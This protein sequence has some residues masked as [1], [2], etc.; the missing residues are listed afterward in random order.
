MKSSGFPLRAATMMV[1]LCLS[2]APALAEEWHSADG[3]DATRNRN[4]PDFLDTTAL[5]K[6]R[7]VPNSTTAGAVIS[8]GNLFTINADSASSDI[9]QCSNLETGTSVFAARVGPSAAPTT[10]HQLLAA[11][12]FVVAVANTISTGN[13]RLR[14]TRSTTLSGTKAIDLTAPIKNATLHRHS[15]SQRLYVV[16]QVGSAEIRGFEITS[17]GFVQ[18]W[19]QAIP[20]NTSITKP[21]VINNKAVFGFFA[22]GFPNNTIAVRS[23]DVETG[24]QTLVDTQTSAL[25]E[26]SSLGIAVDARRNFV[27]FHSNRRIR[28]Y[29]FGN[30]TNPPTLLWNKAFTSGDQRG[31]I[32][33][34][35]GNGLVYTQ[36]GTDLQ[37]IDPLAGGAT[38]R[39]VA[40]GTTTNGLGP[41]LSDGTLWA[42]STNNRIIAKD[43][44]TLTTQRIIAPALPVLGNCFGIAGIADGH[45]IAFSDLGVE[46][47]KHAR[48]VDL[49]QASTGTSF[50]ATQNAAELPT[51][52][53]QGFTDFGVAGG[54]YA[55]N[56]GDTPQPTTALFRL[57]NGSGDRLY[58]TSAAE[59]TSALG[60]GFVSEPDA[61]FIFS[62]S[63]PG[64]KPLHRLFNSATGQHALTANSD[65]LATLGGFVDEGVIGFVR[66][67]QSTALNRVQ[68][69]GG[70]LLSLSQSE[71]ASFVSGGAQNLGAIGRLFASRDDSPELVPLFRLKNQNTGDRLFTSSAT[72]RANALALGTFADEGTEGYVHTRPGAGRKPLLRAL[73]SATGRHR[74][75]TD[76]LEFQA[77]GGTIVREGAVGFVQK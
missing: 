31:G 59:K 68:A 64:R 32:A 3:R 49:F 62:V 77:F 26:P 54:V 19:T 46:Q 22:S 52:F 36:T 29:A 35:E 1:A 37:E 21:A 18:V 2:I 4:S 16:L 60:A 39:S 73:D 40:L 44:A 34:S 66:T 65:D 12:D 43:L 5:G 24:A 45:L 76:P 8:S 41:A 27:Y 33:I 72:E 57:K 28:A 71:T 61:G 51:L 7:T 58:T 10:V 13:G 55:T 63:G 56:T 23:F 69:G 25:T 6:L 53:G 9:V 67:Q 75:T 14:F 11:D 42:T 70:D 50:V 48:S 15:V 38:V 17:T 20:T 74:Y 47:F 30:G